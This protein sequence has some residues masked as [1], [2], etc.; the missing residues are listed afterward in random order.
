[1]LTGVEKN[2]S[3]DVLKNDLFFVKQE[4]YFIRPPEPD[5][6]FSVAIS[7]KIGHIFHLEHETM[8]E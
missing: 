8:E 1:M 2:F 3:P 4:G 7:E 5:C 6:R